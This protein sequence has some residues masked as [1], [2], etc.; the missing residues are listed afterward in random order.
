MRRTSWKVVGVPL[1]V[2]ALAATRLPLTGATEP[3]AA[4]V[5]NAGSPN[6]WNQ[7]LGPNRNGINECG[8][9]SAQ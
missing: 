9:L 2:L 1:V 6:D 7:F 8:T 3:P 4:T 5:P